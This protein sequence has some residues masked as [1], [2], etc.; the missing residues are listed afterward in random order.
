[1]LALARAIPPRYRNYAYVNFLNLAEAEFAAER[2]RSFDF[3][4]HLLRSELTEARST[5]GQRLL[6]VSRA[7]ASRADTAAVPR[8]AM[9]LCSAPVATKTT[10]SGQA[11]LF[12]PPLRPH[13][14]IVL[15][16][17]ITPTTRNIFSNNEAT[18]VVEGIAES[19]SETDIFDT[20]S[21]IGPLFSVNLIRKGD[22]AVRGTPARPDLAALRGDACRPR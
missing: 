21:T 11:T 15:G 22:G 12:S 16:P 4:G 9:G 1:M 7:G 8:N 18:V 10:S 20:F 19:V 14:K 2:M 5:C 6:F 17:G 3:Q 13:S